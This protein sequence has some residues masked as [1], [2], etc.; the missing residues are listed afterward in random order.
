MSD[1]GQ[2]KPVKNESRRTE[3]MIRAGALKPP[4][5]DPGREQMPQCRRCLR[6]TDDSR[7]ISIR[8]AA[9]GRPRCPRSL[10]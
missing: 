6:V 8:A 4:W 7:P 3:E 9:Q 2:K 1:V 10:M 5:G